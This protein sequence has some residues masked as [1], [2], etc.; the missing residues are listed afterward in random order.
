MKFKIDENL[1]AEFAEL[2]V[3]AH[4]DAVTLV[5]QHLQGKE[6]PV[7]METCMREGR[8]FLIEVFRR[9]IPTLKR[10]PIDRRLWIIEE[11]RIRIRG[12]EE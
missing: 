3:A 1:P 11:T 2:L 10:E 4:H 12:E 8:I 9:A 5:S 6:D 7:I